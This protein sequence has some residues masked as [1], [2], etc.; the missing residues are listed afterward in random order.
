V[1]SFHATR[2]TD[3]GLWYPTVNGV[4]QKFDDLPAIYQGNVTTIAPF[5]G[6]A[7]SLPPLSPQ[8]VDDIV[9]FLGT[10]TDGTAP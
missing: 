1:V 3:P 7:G 8:D 4:V 5:D 9:A 6:P 10:L 2:D